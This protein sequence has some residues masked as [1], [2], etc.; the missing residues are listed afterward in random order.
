[1]GVQCSPLF[2]CLQQH[3]MYFINVIISPPVYFNH[4]FLWIQQVVFSRL[5]TILAASLY[6]YFLTD[7]FLNTSSKPRRIFQKYGES[8]MIKLSC[9]ELFSCI[10]S[11]T[12]VWG[13]CCGTALMDSW[14]ACDLLS[15]HHASLQ[16]SCWISHS[17]FCILNLITSARQCLSLVPL[18]CILSISDAS[19]DFCIQFA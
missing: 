11:V 16:N 10:D 3:F 7:F 6:I 9:M 15:F 1:M 13:F 17:S 4:S 19:Y 14:S 12:C 5:L 8:M 2:F 18:S